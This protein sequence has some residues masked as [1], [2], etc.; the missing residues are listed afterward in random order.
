MVLVN[1]LGII[2]LEDNLGIDFSAH[3]YAIRA[4]LFLGI[5]DA[6]V[7]VVDLVVDQV[8]GKV[9]CQP[10]LQKDFLVRFEGVTDA[11]P[12]PGKGTIREVLEQDAFHKG[13]AVDEFRYLTSDGAVLGTAP[14]S[15]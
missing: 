14:I 8:L 1:L 2:L 9:F 13:L 5:F 4:N 3:R 12:L 11:V 10:I 7:H 15:L 6:N